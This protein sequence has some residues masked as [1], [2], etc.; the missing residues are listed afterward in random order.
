[1]RLSAERI[2]EIQKLLLEEHGLTLDGEAAQ[3]AGL[4]IMHFIVIK[5][6]QNSKSV[7][8]DRSTTHESKQA[9]SQS[10]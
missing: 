2:L 1:M 8:K 10:V 3:S 5:Q 6:R 4:A 7:D 9:N